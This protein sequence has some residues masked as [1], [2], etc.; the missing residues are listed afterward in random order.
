MKRIP[1][2][3]P[4]MV[5][6]LVGVVIGLGGV[7]F[8]TIPDSSGTI[9]ACIGKSNGNLRAVEATA[10]CRTNETAIGWNQEGPPGPPGPPGTND[11]KKVD[12][13]LTGDQS[14]VI[15]SEGVLTVTAQC[16]LDLDFRP[17]GGQILDQAR[18]L[19]STSQD[20]VIAFDTGIID[21]TTLERLRE[22]LTVNSPQNEVDFGMR[23]GFALLA[24]DGTSVSGLLWGAVNPP[25]R[26]DTCA[27]GGYLVE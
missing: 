5:V 8:A 9:H 24:P 12:L 4:A 15:F 20:G 26:P 25:G 27:I 19:V 1:R 6:A 3:S 22:I 13:V 2:P 21:T 10:D 14:R 11:L 17:Q 16:R 7:A 18:V 23:E